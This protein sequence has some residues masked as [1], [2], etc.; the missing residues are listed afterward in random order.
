M[1]MICVSMSLVNPTI[2][3]ATNGGLTAV[4]Q[5][6]VRILTPSSRPRRGAGG[7][8]NDALVSPGIWLD[9]RVPLLARTD[10][11]QVSPAILYQRPQN[12]SE[13]PTH[14]KVFDLERNDYIADFD[15]TDKP[16]AILNLDVDLV[17]DNSYRIDLLKEGVD[18]NA[19]VSFRVMP[20][21]RK[22]RSVTAAINRT[23]KPEDRIQVFVDYQLWSDALQEASQYLQPTDD[24]SVFWKE[25]ME[26]WRVPEDKVE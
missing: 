7:K 4:M 11:W 22:R 24:L 12:E 26:S 6:V 9:G 20:M 8:G 3:A 21:G 18:Q 14:L 2:T 23:Q 13:A 25:V 5:N 16:Y 1:I 10:I 15:V 19:S 17:M